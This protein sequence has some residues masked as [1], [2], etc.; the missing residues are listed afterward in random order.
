MKRFFILLKDER[1]SVESALVIIPLLLLFL[2]GMQLTT[3][4]H[5]RNLEKANLQDVVSKR[6]ISG[7]FS[8]T[9]EYIH[10]ASNGDSQNLD[11]LVSHSSHPLPILVPGLDQILGR[12]PEINVDGIAVI[13]NA[14]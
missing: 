8:E 3:S 5:M 14:R 6:A 9:D 11:L 12:V 7:L 4:A 13:E 1:G 10:I 2:I